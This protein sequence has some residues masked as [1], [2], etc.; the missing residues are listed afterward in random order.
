M[1]YSKFK[2]IYKTNK[3]I[4]RF[5]LFTQYVFVFG[6]IFYMIPGNQIPGQYYMRLLYIMMRQRRALRQQQQND[7]AHLDIIRFYSWKFNYLV[8]NKMINPEFLVED[9]L[10]LCRIIDQDQLE[11]SENTNQI[12]LECLAYFSNTFIPG[13]LKNEKF[14]PFLKKNQLQTA[15]LSFLDI[16]T[17]KYDPKSQYQIQL[18]KLDNEQFQYATAMMTQFVN[19]SL[20]LL[21][22][23]EQSDIRIRTLTYQIYCDFLTK[24]ENKYDMADSFS[25]GEGIQAI[26]TEYIII[27]IYIFSL[28]NDESQEL[29][30]QALKTLRHLMQQDP[31][32]CIKFMKLKILSNLI[33]HTLQDDRS[34]EEEIIK[35]IQSFKDNQLRQKLIKESQDFK[36]EYKRLEGISKKEKCDFIKISPEMKKILTECL[37]I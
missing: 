17:I 26:L 11:E 15:I 6:F 16:I 20:V 3:Q 12:I 34:T 35:I 14:L 8:Q 23:S 28:N 25:N 24:T 32:V 30:Y 13:I 36:E 2:Q 1:L 4:R 33:I 37:Q 27:F 5:I 19:L 10:G 7:V 9:I 18:E 21:K 22:Y 29:K 31:L